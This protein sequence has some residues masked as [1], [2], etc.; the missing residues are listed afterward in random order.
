MALQS[1]R[2]AHYGSPRV[3]PAR[4]AASR[5]ESVISEFPIPT[6]SSDADS[7]TAADRLLWFTGVR[8]PDEI[9]RI[10]TG[11]VVYRI[12]DPTAAPPSVITTGPDGE[13]WFTEQ[14]GNNI[15]RITV[16]HQHPRLQRRRQERHPLARRRRQYQQSG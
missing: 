2:T 6:T 5:P 4:L 12:V 8:T 9:G 11:G 1:G 3:R 7:F 13:L 14:N 10:A 15:G 16:S